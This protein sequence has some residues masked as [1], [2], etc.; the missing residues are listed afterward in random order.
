MRHCDRGRSS[1][2]IAAVNAVDRRVH[3][4]VISKKEKLEQLVEKL[5]SKGVKIDWVPKTCSTEEGS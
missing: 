5:K 3:P 4:M 2:D 1:D